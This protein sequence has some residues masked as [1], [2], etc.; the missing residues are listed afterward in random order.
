M[1][2]GGCNL[3]QEDFGDGDASDWWRSG[4]AVWQVLNGRLQVQSITGG[5]VARAQ[6]PVPAQIEERECFDAI[7]LAKDVDG[8]TCLGFGRM[9][10]VEHAWGSA[11]PAGI[12]RLLAAM[13]ACPPGAPYGAMDDVHFAVL[14]R[15]RQLKQDVTEGRS[16]SDAMAK[17]PRI[18]SDLYVN[19]VRAGESSGALVALVQHAARRP[20]ARRATR[21]AA[22]AV[23][24]TSRWPTCGAPWLGKA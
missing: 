23:V 21:R 6:H 14:W 2:P 10:M 16:L 1:P 7:A 9:A 11:T 13:Q 4:G 12:M 8:V 17:Q 3:F 24:S 22:I 20:K 15:L 18:F 5:G 19:M